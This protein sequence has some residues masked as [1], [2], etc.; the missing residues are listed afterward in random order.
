MLLNP[1]IGQ[2]VQVW[3]KDRDM[4]YHGR[5][6]IVRVASRGKP[7]NHCVEIEGVMV[8]VPCGNLRKV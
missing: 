3:Y 4:L 8:S 1:R 6:G 5:T 2:K 7:R